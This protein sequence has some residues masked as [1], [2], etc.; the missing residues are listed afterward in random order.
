MALQSISTFCSS[1]IPGL[2]S[3]EYAPTTL[4][5]ADVY[6]QRIDG[7]VW[8]SGV[9]FSS[10][11]WL[12]FPAF[13]RPDQLWSQTQRDSTQGRSYDNVVS[14]S[15]PSLRVEVD[16][17][18]AQ[19]DDYAYLLRLKDRNGKYWLLGTLENPFYFLVNSSSGSGGSRNGYDFE[20]TSS[21]PERVYGLIL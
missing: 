13:Y 21:L 10:G 1:N 7:H 11:G 3:I 15:T 4:I 8:D 2:Y 19:M 18:F 12:S 9:P 20:F 14:G 17:Q 5:D 6:R 16:E